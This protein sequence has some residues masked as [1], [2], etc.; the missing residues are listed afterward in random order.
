MIKKLLYIVIFLIPLTGFCQDRQ[1]LQGRVV[2]GNNG[3]KEVYVINKTAGT[4]AKTNS[5]GYFSL[6]AKPGDALTIYSPK[7]IIRE[8][9]LNEDSFKTSPFLI[10]VNYQAYELNEVVIDKY[11]KIDSES[12][13]LVPK[14]QKRHTVAERRLYTATGGGGISIGTVVGLDP[15]INA[16]S[17]RTRMLKRAYETEKLEMAIENVTGIYNE[18]EIADKFKIPAEY[19]NGFLFYLAESKE[20]AAAIKQKNKSLMDFLMTGLADKYLKL[21]SDDK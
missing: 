15:I 19:M 8:F 18:D 7:I 4:E 9:A 2:A 1:Q 16:I 3:I 17:G 14:G 21:I 6:M 11:G 12:L 5:G 20:L 10:T 13:G